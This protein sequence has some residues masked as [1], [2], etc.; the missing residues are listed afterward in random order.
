LETSAAQ[1]LDGHVVHVFMPR[2][3]QAQHI[4]TRVSHDVLYS[5]DFVTQ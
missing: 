5:V 2:L 3:R 4:D 1:S